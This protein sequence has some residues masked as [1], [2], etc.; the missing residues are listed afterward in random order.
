MTTYMYVYLCLSVFL[1]VCLSLCSSL[2]FD[3]FVN[4]FQVVA[5]LMV[6]GA[7]FSGVVLL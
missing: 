5:L 2:S 7:N 4:V 1:S 3:P 6:Q